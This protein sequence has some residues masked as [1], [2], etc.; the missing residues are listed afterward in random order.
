MVVVIITL[1]T[2]KDNFKKRKIDMNIKISSSFMP[3]P[4]REISGSVE[5]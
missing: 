2:L 1:I 3:L 4:C 5:S